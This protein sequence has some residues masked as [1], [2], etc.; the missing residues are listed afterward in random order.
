MKNSK[1]RLVAVQVVA[2]CAATMLLF[3]GAI[4]K[5]LQL[6][7]TPSTKNLIF[8]SR[9]AESFVVLFEI[10]L[11]FWLISGWNFRYATRVTAIVLCLF[12][13]LNLT[14]VSRGQTSCGCFGLVQVHPLITL[15]LDLIVLVLLL[16]C[17]KSVGR[18]TI[19]ITP[20]TILFFVCQLGLF[21]TFAS[22]QKHSLDELVD[23]GSRSG[24]VV[25]EL[26]DLQGKP[27]Q[28]FEYIRNADVQQ[29]RQGNWEVVLVHSGCTQC[30]EVI[31][32]KI[33]AIDSHPSQLAIIELPPYSSD[34][35]SPSKSVIR[36][37]LS[38]EQKWFAETP[39]VFKLDD[40]IVK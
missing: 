34:V 5:W 13:V 40:G 1:T 39:L 3:S 17:T 30:E 32:E 8:G 11:A 35:F 18:K 9:M 26:E 6:A 22:V 27:F 21:A 2:I 10:G 12:L 31:A 20:L 28:L 19:L 33:A 23:L 38:N 15:F 37:R 7:S 14:A 29:L 16:T 25:I 24:F 4:L 36:G